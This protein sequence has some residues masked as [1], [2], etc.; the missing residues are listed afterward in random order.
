MAETKKNTFIEFDT[1][2]VSKLRLNYHENQ[3][4]I[5]LDFFS[6]ERYNYQNTEYLRC[7][8]EDDQQSLIQKPGP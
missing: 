5:K 3:V 8:L 2:S 7:L 4:S 6:I 1:H